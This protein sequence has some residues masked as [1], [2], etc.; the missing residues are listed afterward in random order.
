MAFEVLHRVET[1]GAFASV[2]LDHRQGSIPD[3]REAALAREIVL[4][5]LRQRS[6][7]DHVLSRFSSRPLG[8]LDPDVRTA[9]RIGAYQI[10]FLERVPDFA[11][12]DA[13]VELLKT[14]AQRRAAGYV[15][16]VL[17]S[18]AREGRSALPPEPVPGDV[19]GL[20]LR[21]SHPEWWVARLVERLGFDAS[22]DLLASDNLPVAPVLCPNPRSADVSALIRELADHGVSVEPARFVPQALRVRSGLARQTPA[23]DEG[24]I[25][26]QDEASQ[27]IPLLFDADP[28]ARRVA[29]LCA[30]PG[31]KTMQ[32]ASRF[33]AAQL[34]ACDRH[35]GRVR[36]MRRSLSRVGL[37]AVVTVIADVGARFP[38][39]AAAAFDRVLVDAPCTG[40]G[41]LRRH[42]E[43][44][45]R[46]RP[47]DPVR[48]A[49]IQERILDRAA[50]LVARGGQLVY[51]VCSLE[52][53][54][55]EGVLDAF[56]RNHR[57]FA[58][59][60]PSANLPGPARALLDERGFL[61]TSPSIGGLDGFFAALLVRAG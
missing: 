61:R 40:T 38:P 3:A 32:L 29:D 60:D 28:G 36:T 8:K 53:E 43:I 34:V 45:W 18:V 12:V 44:R 57:E 25:W 2:L 49:A 31:G 9:L 55:G 56:L 22:A 1:A 4:G 42:P 46:L 24:R 54:E 20:A 10:L 39:L 33:P 19:P 26:F 23:F 50:G 37:D 47:A 59:A 48:L 51:S 17:R 14:G 13:T 11:A 15:N 5:T 27:L 41:T 30:A 16:A 6:G 58:I 52:P 35:A 7:V 21:H